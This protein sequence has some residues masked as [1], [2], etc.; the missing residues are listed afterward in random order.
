MTTAVATAAPGPPPATVP[1]GINLDE[2]MDE[3][4][5]LRMKGQSQKEIAAAMGVDISTVCRWLKRI[6]AKFR[7]A[8]EGETPVD[9]LSRELQKLDQCE[10]TAR[11]LLEK[12][13]SDRS[14]AAYLAEI[15][16]CSALR[17]RIYLDSGLIERVPDRIFKIIGHWRVKELPEVDLEKT[18]QEL[19]DSLVQKQLERHEATKG[20]EFEKSMDE[21]TTELLTI[22]SRSPRVE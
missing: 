22:L 2:K 12:T 7:E 14:K 5:S 1:R 20:T 17:M 15:R 8:M 4:Y 9:L 16:R 18:K 3:A 10:N 11:Q 21:T 19:L 6:E 13:K